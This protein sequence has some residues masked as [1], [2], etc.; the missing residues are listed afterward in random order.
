MSTTKLDYIKVYPIGDVCPYCG[1]PVQ[2]DPHMGCC[3]EVHHERGFETD[4]EEIILES[5]LTDR[6]VIEDR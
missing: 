2:I 4:D 6:H 1:S 5:E 3:G